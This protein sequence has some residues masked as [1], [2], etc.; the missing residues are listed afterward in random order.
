MFYN[1]VLRVAH[2][3]NVIADSVASAVVVVVREV[4]LALARLLRQS[5]SGRLDPLNDFSP[6]WSRIVR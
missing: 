3:A 1:R 5:G 2:N 6:D 4:L